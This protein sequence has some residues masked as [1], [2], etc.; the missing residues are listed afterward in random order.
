MTKL[1]CILIILFLLALRSSSQLTDLKYTPA[2][3][4]Y[5]EDEAFQ[6]IRKT[7]CSKFTTRDKIRFGISVLNCLYAITGHPLIRCK[8]SESIEKCRGRLSEDENDEVFWYGTL[9]YERHCKSLSLKNIIPTLRGMKEKFERT[10]SRWRERQKEDIRDGRRVEKRLGDVVGR[11]D[12]VEEESRESVRL[13]REAT[14]KTIRNFGESTREMEGFMEGLRKSVEG[15]EELEGMARSKIGELS[16]LVE[17]MKR[18][19]CRKRKEGVLSG[20]EAGLILSIDYLLVV[21]IP[22]G[23]GEKSWMKRK[24][25]YWITCGLLPSLVLRKVDLESVIEM[26]MRNDTGMY[27]HVTKVGGRGMVW[28]RSKEIDTAAVAKGTFQI[29]LFSYTAV[30]ALSIIATAFLPMF[31]KVIFSLP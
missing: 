21:L 16:G 23:I 9:V 1:L 15:Q 24:L 4:T 20:T 19:K 14:R 30:Y 3:E 29:V 5:C 17:D 2:D 22:F 8:S 18:F 6:S 7:S 27:Q 28:L 25:A 12:E 13:L 31:V 26:A 10:M 11:L